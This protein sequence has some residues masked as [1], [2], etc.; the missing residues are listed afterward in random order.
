MGRYSSGGSYAHDCVYNRSYGGWYEISWQ[1]DRYYSGSRLRF[2]QRRGRSTD[3]KG[4]RRFCKRWDIPFP[5]PEQ[6]KAVS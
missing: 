2:P 6:E 3:E 5:E 4:A 1:Y